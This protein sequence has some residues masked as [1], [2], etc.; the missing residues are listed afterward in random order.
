MAVKSSAVVD[1]RVIFCGDNLEQLKKLPPGCI[2]L[3]YIDPLLGIVRDTNG[4]VL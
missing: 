4:L 2:D 3:V 1:T